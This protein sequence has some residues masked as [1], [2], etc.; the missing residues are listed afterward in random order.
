MHRFFLVCASQIISETW[1]ITDILNSLVFPS[2]L[3]LA[4]FRSIVHEPW[5]SGAHRRPNR[6]EWVSIIHLMFNKT[7]SIGGPHMI[8]YR[9]LGQ[10]LRRIELRPSEQEQ[11]YFTECR[12]KRNSKTICIREQNSTCTT[13]SLQRSIFNGHDTAKWMVHGCLSRAISNPSRIH[14]KLN[15][16]PS[17]SKNWIVLN[18]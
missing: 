17:L 1:Y 13:L 9:G 6:I 12:A 7:L 16:Q 18:W 11:D 8:S 3:Q 15:C 4:E 2:W 5:G 10:R 14:F